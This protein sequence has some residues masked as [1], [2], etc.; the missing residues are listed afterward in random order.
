MKNVLFVCVENSCRSQMAEAYANMYGQSVIKAY[1]SGSHPAGVVNP[2]AIKAMQQAGYDLSVHESKGLDAIPDISYDLVITMG[3][4]DQCPVVRA[5]A[6]Q[7][8][9]QASAPIMITK[10]VEKGNRSRRVRAP[11]AAI[12]R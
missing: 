10:S 5:K 4:G 2:K 11:E 6:R 1:S 12:G 9:K 3:C 8:C 7:D